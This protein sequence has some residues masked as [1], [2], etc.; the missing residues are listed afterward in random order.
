MKTLM[1][2][3]AL[4][5]MLAAPVVAPLATAG[6]YPQRPVKFVVPWPAGDLEDVLTRMIAEEMSKETGTPATVVNKPGGGGVVGATDVS[7]SRNDGLTI[8]SFV[9]D[10]V[11][12]QLLAGNAPYDENTFEP[13]GI[14]LDYP[15]VLATKASSPYNNVAELATYSASNKVSLGHFGYQALPTAITFKAA[16]KSG[17]HFSSDAAFDLNDCSTLAN[18]DADVINTTTQLILACLKS[19]EVKLLASLTRDRL[20]IAPDVATLNEQTGVTQTTWNG[21]FVK[22]GTPV[23]IKNRIAEIAQKALASE[24][25]KALSVSTGAGVFWVGGED[26]QKV[27]SRD[28]NEARELIQYIKR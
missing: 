18:G 16:A 14:F 27:V 10:L 5:A 2:T 25:A 17:I 3:C 8:G 4:I 9:A 13:V 1:K 15:F 21:L 19:G 23:E 20:S 7:R 24:Q 11:T 12:T 28:Y 6:E 26:A 22:R